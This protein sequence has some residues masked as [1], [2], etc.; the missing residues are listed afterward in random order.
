MVFD[1]ADLTRRL[2]RLGLK[3]LEQRG[4]LTIR[5]PSD[6]AT[7]P[8]QSA[9]DVDVSGLPSITEDFVEIATLGQGGMGRVVLARQTS[10][11]REVAVKTLNPGATSAE[12]AALVREGRVTGTIE[13][14]S[15]VPIHALGRDQGGH[16]LLVMKR[17]EGVSWE[18]LLADPAHPAA[19][20]HLG[21]ARDVFGAHIGIFIAVCR[22]LEL[23]HA[24]GIIHRDVKPENVMV[25]AFGEVYLVD[26]GL[27]TTKE[28][29]AGEG[30]I[31]GTPSYMAPEMAIGGRVDERTDVYLLGAT[32]HQVLTGEPRHPIDVM[33][34]VK[35]AIRSEPATYGTEIPTT[36][37]EICNRACARD[38]AHRFPSVQDFREAVVAFQRNKS[39]LAI[40]SVANARL[41]ELTRVLGE[42]EGPPADL[43][44]AYRLAT[45]AKF[46]FAQSLEQFPEHELARVGARRCIEIAAELELRQGHAETA[47]ALLEGLEAPPPSLLR[48]VDSL[49]NEAKS[50]AEEDARIRARDRELDPRIGRRTRVNGFLLVLTATIAI[51][52][53]MTIAERNGPIGP[54]ALVIMMALG[55]ALTLL[56][57]GTLRK[58]L[59]TTLFNRRLAA[60]AL[61]LE[62]SFLFNRTLSWIRNT[63]V[64]VTL[65]HDLVIGAAMMLVASVLFVPRLAICLPLLVIALVGVELAPEHAQNTFAIAVVLLGAAGAWALTTHRRSD[66]TEPL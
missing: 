52:A 60:F 36:L 5:A 45:E 26:W 54:V 16:P 62:S 63:P 44:R 11:S 17:V 21:D 42:S 39:A 1:D 2:E 34:A 31:V 14:P 35:A 59:L 6:A 65:G 38:P 30:C 33:A 58:R 8:T 43:A 51:R 12:V 41:E 49:R 9:F 32:L 28:E 3:T 10:L 53:T 22:A 19:R 47:A 27:A 46:G 13:H 56:V 48:R 57:I 20:T 64:H 25:G 7:I 40:S 18:A 24:R 4:S 29:A 55:I 23:A 37:G 15:I 50:R 61:V 66:R